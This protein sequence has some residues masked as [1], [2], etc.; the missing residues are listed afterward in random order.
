MTIDPLWIVG[1]GV[2]LT[3]VGVGA[4]IRLTERVTKLE[5][6]VHTDLHDRVVALEAVL[7][8]IGKKAARMLHSPHDPWGI[9]EFLEHY[10]DN[11]YDLPDE[12]WKQ[13][14]DKLTEVQ[15]K[16]D[17]DAKVLAML[18]ESLAGFT[19]ALAEHKMKRNGSNPSI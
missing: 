18:V 4:Y 8:L 5:A 2:A 19:K 3:L 12:E 1:Q 17:M 7:D 16:G 14:F 9:D 10:I 15:K 6:T 13:L 11:D